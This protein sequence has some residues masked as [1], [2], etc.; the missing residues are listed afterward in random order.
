MLQTASADTKKATAR[1]NSQPASAPDGLLLAPPVPALGNQAT[2]RLL[3]KCDCGGAPDCDCGMGDDKKKKEKDSPRTALHRKP[4]GSGAPLPSSLLDHDTQSFFE[5]RL[6]RKAF[7]SAV[8]PA[9]PRIQIGAVDDPLEA[10]ADRTAARVL[11]M[12][13]S[14]ISSVGRTGAPAPGSLNRSAETG[15]APETRNDG[16]SDGREAP[17]SVYEVLGQPGRQLDPSTRAFFEPRFGQDLSHVRIHNDSKAAESA[18]AV[19][20][21]AFASGHNIVF[22]SGSYS[23][24]RPDGRFMLAHEL[25]HTMQQGRQQNLR[26]TIRSAPT[27]PL[28]SYLNGKKIVGFTSDSGSYS[29]PRGTPPIVIQQEV[30]LDMLASAR[31][32]E[33]AG[34]TSADAEKSLDNHVTA[35]LGIVTFASQ[36]KYSFASVNG[37][38]MNPQYWITDPN[39]QSYKLKPGVDKQAAWDDLN[40]NPQEYAIG[41]Y[42]A[43]DITQAGGA[44]GAQFR[45][46]PSTDEN[47]WVPGDAGYVANPNHPK[48]DDPGTMGEN[49]IYTGSGMFW[50]HL[51]NDVTYRTL[52]EWKKV[53]A[54]WNGSSQVDPKRD[55]PMTGLL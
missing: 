40:Q 26:R 50:G 37:F 42:A 24:D 30:L 33:I 47:D 22:G 8:A 51:S 6:Q 49:I 19:N 53:V 43:T 27:A 46:Q 44:K 4:A 39:T 21:L 32:F 12:P 31:L 13:D 1:G 14:A 36:K 16:I 15:S 54:R 10:D 9:G 3:R 34:D 29:I 25:A 7:S 41:C 52:D 35:R 18:R 38:K 17:P 2:L 23:P 20:A 48:Q 5:A 28:D 45:N 11:R 55:G